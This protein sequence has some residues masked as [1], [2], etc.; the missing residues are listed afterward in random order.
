VTN[1]EIDS[2]LSSYAAGVEAELSLLRQLHEHALRQ[3]DATS[4]R[5]SDLVEPIA[6]GRDR[7]M[8]GLLEIESQLR[9]LRDVIA[10][11]TA[12]AA[13]RPTFT[14]TSTLHRVASTIVRN[15]LGADEQTL[16]ALRNAEAVRREAAKALETGGTTLA[17]YRRVIA[18]PIAH[19]SLFD[20][21]G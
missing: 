4:G 7:I 9:P 13:T 6:A 18:P 20:D 2:V 16:G 3:R 19:P 5:T 10:A 1:A 12:L 8:G 11:N 14:E 17:A 21:R 15:I